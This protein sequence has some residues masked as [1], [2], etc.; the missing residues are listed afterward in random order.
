MNR[1]I[2]I[3]LS[4]LSS[5]VACS[6]NPH[7][8]ESI[9]TQLDQSTTVSGTQNVG[10]KKGEMVVIDKTQMAEKLRDLQNQVYSLEDRV[11]GTRKLGSLG[12]YGDLKSCRRKLASR[13]YGGSGT[14]VWTEPLDR[15]TDKEEEFKIGLDEKKELVGVTEEYLRDR[16][17]RFQGYRSIL[18]KRADDFDQ[19]I[20]AC[21]TEIGSKKFDESLSS[22][23][24]VQEIPKSS[25]DRP[26][27][28][29]F[30]C[31]Y[32]K[33]G[34]SLQTFMINAFAK[35]WLSIGD[36]RMENNLMVPT[37]KDS[38]GKTRDN[39]LLFNGWKLAYDA[40]SIT[41]GDVLKEGKDARLVAW[42]YDKKA[43]VSGAGK[44]LASSDGQWNP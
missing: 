28:N 18:Q 44:C 14:L 41:V 5:L 13:Q 11:Y 42:T 2:W 19:Q 4:V 37:L 43:E 10:L 29:Q 25:L 9:Q 8:A 34:A 27:I 35:G 20:D 38:A 1:Y 17:G 16:L 24:S 15:V 32:V 36:Y 33:P 3:S 22:K 30:M 26:S 21:T 31:E 40:S 7:K 6:T 39:A 12:L 23:V